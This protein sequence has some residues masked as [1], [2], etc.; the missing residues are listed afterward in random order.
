MLEFL[1]DN[2]FLFG[3]RVFQ[4]TV[5]FAINTNCAPLHPELFSTLTVNFLNNTHC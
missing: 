1:I 5:G 3:R 2:N 4:Q